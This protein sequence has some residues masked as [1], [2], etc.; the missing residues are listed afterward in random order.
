MK[1]PATLRLD[2]LLANMGYGSRRDVQWM[3]NNGLL[4]LDGAVVADADQR[5]AITSDLPARMSVDGEPMKKRR[6]NASA[7]TTPAQRLGRC[8]CGRAR[9][10]CIPSFSAPRSPR[11]GADRW[12]SRRMRCR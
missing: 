8:R 9:G 11:A 1:K 2:R 5:I 4:V 10:N 7:C 12:T 6:S 3:A